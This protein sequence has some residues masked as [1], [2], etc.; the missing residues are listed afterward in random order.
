MSRLNTPQWIVV[1]AAVTC[2]VLFS[3]VNTVPQARKSTAEASAKQV[4]ES[5]SL[6]SQLIQAHTRLSADDRQLL[7]NGETLL[8]QQS[9]YVTKRKILDSLMYFALSRKEYVLAA[10]FAQQKAEKCN[11]SSVDW[12]TAGERF[13]NAIAFMGEKQ[14]P[15]FISPLFESAMHC[16]QEALSLDANNLDARVGLGSVIVQG[17]SDPMAGIQELLAVE[18]ADSTNLS[19][20]LAL[21]DFAMRSQQYDKAIA[22]YE[23]ALRLR[24]DLYGLHLSL[25]ELFERKGDTANTVM[26]LEAYLKKA[27]DPIVKNDVENAVRRLRRK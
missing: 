27:D 9:E 10:W 19:A 11:G 21:G 1:G 8:R 25:A 12:Q 16:F 24:P 17:T 20:Q 26:N 22:R 14:G 6:D 7:I 13:Q 2:I 23:K 15:Q 5:V 4:S 3:F 18:K